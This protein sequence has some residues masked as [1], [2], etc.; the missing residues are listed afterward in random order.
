MSHRRPIKPGYVWGLLS[1]TEPPDD[2]DFAPVEC[3]EDDY[4][5]PAEADDYLSDQAA[6]RYQRDID[7]RHP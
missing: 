4:I 7:A 6:D 5:E 1:N 2:D 3:S